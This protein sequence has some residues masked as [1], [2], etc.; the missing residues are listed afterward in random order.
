LS[1]KA[2]SRSP[3]RIQQMLRRLEPR[4]RQRFPLI[5]DEV[6]LTEILEEA[7]RLLVE[8]ELAAGPIEKLR[9]FAWVTVSNVAKSRLRRGPMRLQHGDDD[10]RVFA[11]L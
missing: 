6:V 5:R 10:R 9:G 4:L 2:D 3:D 8:R 7:G 1:I 11:A